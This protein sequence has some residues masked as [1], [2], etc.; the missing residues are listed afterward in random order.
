MKT[1]GLHGAKVRNRPLHRE[2]RVATEGLAK[3]SSVNKAVNLNEAVN[4]KQSRHK[5]HKHKNLKMITQDNTSNVTVHDSVT[6]LKIRWL[7]MALSGF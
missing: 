7:M 1:R 6:T 3:Q 5:Q 2:A 4:S